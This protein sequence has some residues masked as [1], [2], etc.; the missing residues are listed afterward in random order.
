MLLAPLAKLAKMDQRE[1]AVMQASQED[2]ETLDFVEL[3]VHLERKENPE[4]MDP[5]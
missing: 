5:L 2:R 4:R 1:P 3:L